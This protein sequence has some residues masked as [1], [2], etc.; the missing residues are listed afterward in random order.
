ML[1]NWYC[2]PIEKVR[3]VA[4]V[5]TKVLRLYTEV[6]IYLSIYLLACNVSPNLIMTL[7]CPDPRWRITQLP[8][9]T[10]TYNWVTIMLQPS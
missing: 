8:I 2:V 5:A 4:S 7:H 10:K 3:M 9:V 6:Q 1:Y